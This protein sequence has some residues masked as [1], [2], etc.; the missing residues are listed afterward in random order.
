MHVP[1]VY[2]LPVSGKNILALCGKVAFLKKHTIIDE[3]FCIVTLHSAVRPEHKD[4][5]FEVMTTDDGGANCVMTDLGEKGEGMEQRQ[6]A[7]K[8]AGAAVYRKGA[9][10][11]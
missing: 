11:L 10:F 1:Q 6:A 9:T 5:F 2:A 3:D 4:D 7:F 8:K